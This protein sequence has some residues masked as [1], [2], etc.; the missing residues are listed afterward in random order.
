M[1]VKDS[2]IAG[3]M[4]VLNARTE[5]GSAVKRLVKC[6]GCE[7]ETDKLWDVGDGKDYCETCALRKY[8]MGTCSMLQP[9]FNPF[10]NCDT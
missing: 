1:R 6:A 10:S 2:E 5:A 4:K 7:T 3:A 8:D 9:K